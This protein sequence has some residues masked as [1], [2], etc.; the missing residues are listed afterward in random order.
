MNENVT[1]SEMF[2]ALQ[3]LSDAIPQMRFGQLVA[4]VGELCA[5]LHGRGLWEAADTEFLEAVW[6]FHRNFDAAT[7]TS[8][9]HV[10]EPTAAPD[11]AH[12]GFASPQGS[13]GAPG[14]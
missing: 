12:V 10:P 7:V 3:S 4:A 9:A 1:R 8:V 13:I 5:D 2:A 6:Q 14:G 11:L